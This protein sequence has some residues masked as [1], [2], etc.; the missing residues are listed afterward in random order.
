MQSDEPTAAD[1][2]GLKI[3]CVVLAGGQGA[4]IGGDK[5]MRTLAGR[6]LLA[7]ALDHAARWSTDI[8]VAVRDAGQLAGHAATALAD[9]PAIPGPAAGLVSALRF[10]RKRGADAVLAI[11]ADMPFLPGDLA[12]RLGDRIGEAAAALASSGGQLHPVCGLWRTA[13]LDQAPDYFAA[14]RRSLKGLAAT[15]GF[16]EVDWPV[17]AVDPFFNVNTM[18]ELAEAE[19]LLLR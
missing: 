2:A 14:G 15:V 10:A 7:R 1:L 8:A 18:D 4:R 17:A 12:E 13:V 9:D 5:P 19:R 6:S 16:V 11:A 3:A